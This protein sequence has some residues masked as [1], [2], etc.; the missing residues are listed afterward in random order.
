ML[1]TTIATC[2]SLGDIFGSD[3]EEDKPQEELP[4]IAPFTSTMPLEYQRIEFMRADGT[5]IFEMEGSLDQCT[6]AYT[7]D[8]NCTGFEWKLSGYC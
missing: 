7:T 3:D 6:L 2:W 8:V 5:T 1:L 4:P